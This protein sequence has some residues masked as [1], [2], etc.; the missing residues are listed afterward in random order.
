MGDVLQK[1]A[2]NVQVQNN[3]TLKWGTYHNG[4]YV[5][6]LNPKDQNNTL[7]KSGINYGLSV[8]LLEGDG[9]PFALLYHA[10]ATFVSWA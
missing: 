1:C 10:D 8:S 7:I 9:I 5:A 2:K 3:P 6:T 4:K